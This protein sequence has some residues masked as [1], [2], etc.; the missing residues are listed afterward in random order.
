MWERGTQGKMDVSQRESYLIPQVFYMPLCSP[1]PVPGNPLPWGLLL[2]LFLCVGRYLLQQVPGS[3]ALKSICTC[4]HHAYITIYPREQNPCPLH[5]YLYPQHLS[6]HLALCL[7]NNHGEKKTDEVTGVSL[8][9]ISRANSV[10]WGKQEI[11]MLLGLGLNYRCVTL[12][13]A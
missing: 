1:A 12:D 11:W 10:K 3:Q 7:I 4:L 2:V 6:Q 9:I 13:K 5:S 8:E